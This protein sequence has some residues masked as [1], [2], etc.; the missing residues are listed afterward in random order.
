MSIAF[1]T[2]INSEIGKILSEFLLNK[3]YIVYGLSS[4]DII[5]KKNT[6]LN[7]FYGDIT[8]FLKIYT[9]LKKI[10]KE[11]KNF[12]MF[13]IYNLES[14]SDIHKSFKEPTYTCY[15][16]S[17]GTLNLLEAIRKLNMIKKIKFFQE[18]SSE[19][20][21]KCK[22]KPL[23]ENTPFCPISPY[24]TSKLFA[25]W[26]VKNYR[27]TYGLFASNGILFNHS[28]FNSSENSVLKKITAG[29]SKIIRKEEELLI[30]G[31]LDAKRDWGYTNDY[32]E[33]VWMI[34]QHNKADDFVLC[35]GESHTVREIVEKTFNYIGIVIKWEG[36]GINE[37]GK[38]LNTGKIYVK[39]SE[40]YFKPNEIQ[41]LEGMPSKIK[42]IL[43]WKHKMS[44][45]KLI[46]NM[47][48]NDI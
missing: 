36:Y 5:Q 40:E 13:E 46:K 33:G 48:I 39:I 14:Q 44:F 43:G 47:L 21:G 45:E 35:T 6:K 11:H 32:I 17:I 1:I 31:N 26:I 28:N 22:E 12:D 7:I 15:V 38:C 10:F 23:Y 30:L 41:I 9:V 2:G 42:N 20:Y 37:V 34:L 29:V 18:S 24:G 16:N 3:N 4:I 19:I 27:E 25:Y 8:D